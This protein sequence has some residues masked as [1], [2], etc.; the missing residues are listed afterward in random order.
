[1]TPTAEPQKVT[2]AELANAT[3]PCQ[4]TAWTTVA[5]G[6]LGSLLCYLAHPPVGWSQLAWI[7]PAAWFYLARMP[8]MPGRRPYRALWLAGTVYWLATVQWIRLP[9]ELNIFGL[10]LLAAYLG[11]YLPLIVGLSRVAVF[12]L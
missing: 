7:G 1:M 9:H 4:T 8:V 10:F 5:L 6:F 12:H 2:A 11:A 3:P